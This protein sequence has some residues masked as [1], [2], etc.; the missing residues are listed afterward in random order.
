MPSRLFRDPKKGSSL[1][2]DWAFGQDHEPIGKK[3]SLVSDPY[4]IDSVN[5]P[6]TYQQEV[7]KVWGDD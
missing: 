5:C 3:N 2:G 7:S 1:E 6:D 4:E